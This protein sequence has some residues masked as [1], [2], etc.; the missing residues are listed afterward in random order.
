M[1]GAMRRVSRITT[2]FLDTHQGVPI[3]GEDHWWHAPSDAAFKNH[4]KLEPSNSFYGQGLWN[5]GSVRRADQA[6]GDATA[7]LWRDLYDY[8]EKITKEDLDLDGSP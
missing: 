4:L 1:N 3:V 2:R 7:A 8:W 5:D 6:V